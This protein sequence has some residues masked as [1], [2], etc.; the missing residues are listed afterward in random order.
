MSKFSV[1]EVVVIVDDSSWINR[2]NNLKYIGCEATVLALPG[3]GH[4]LCAD[5]DGYSVEVHGFANELFFPNER[6]LRKRRP[7]DDA[8]PKR[9]DLELGDWDLC[10]W[11]PAKERV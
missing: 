2:N 6:L 8:E 11:R 1:G 4:L 3:H 5:P 9:E 10:P 7:K